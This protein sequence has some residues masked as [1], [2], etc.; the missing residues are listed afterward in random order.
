VSAIWEV[1]DGFE[2]GETN[3]AL[4]LASIIHPKLDLARPSVLS[5][6]II[7]HFS[8]ELTRFFR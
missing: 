2:V 7:R 1:E 8:D 5:D 3:S 4:R 6:D